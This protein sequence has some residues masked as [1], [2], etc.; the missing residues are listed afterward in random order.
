M[1]SQMQIYILTLASAAPVCFV[2]VNIRLFTTLL[3]L[4]RLKYKTNITMRFKQKAQKIQG[5]IFVHFLEDMLPHLML[6]KP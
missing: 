2:K 5:Q 3:M 1:M 4:H 6:G